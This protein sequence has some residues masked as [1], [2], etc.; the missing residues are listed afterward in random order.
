MPLLRFSFCDRRG[1]AI[2]PIDSI[3]GLNM[4]LRESKI[5]GNF[6]ALNTAHG[7]S[8]FTEVSAR[9]RE[10]P[11]DRLPDFKTRAVLTVV[12]EARVKRKPIAGVAPA[13]PYQHGCVRKLTGYRGDPLAA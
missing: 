8:S 3:P 9:A 2:W 10:R 12:L 1:G 4:R 13:V 6:L 11:L 7:Y 5:P